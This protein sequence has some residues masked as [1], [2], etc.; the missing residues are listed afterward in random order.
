MEKHIKPKI[1]QNNLIC[2]IENHFQKYKT[3]YS[4]LLLVIIFIIVWKKYGAFIM[5]YCFESKEKINVNNDIIDKD[6]EVLDSI[7]EIH[8]IL[9]KM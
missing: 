6:S 5:N 2:E 1:K 3:F 7:Q 4:S 8:K 9:S